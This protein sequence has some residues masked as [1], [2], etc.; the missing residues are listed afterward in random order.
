MSFK[1]SQ[2]D[3]FVDDSERSLIEKCFRDRWLTEGPFARAFQEALKSQTGANHVFFAPNGTLG[4]YLALLALDL[5]PG[6]EIVMPTFTFYASAT[7][8]VFA[9]LKPVFVDVD[10]NTFNATPHAFESAIGP[11]T[12]AF[13]P[14][15]IYG[16]ACDVE[17]IV[18][19]A[20]RHELKV[21][22]DAAQAL[23]VTLNGKAAGTFG[24][25]G[26]YSLFADKV[27]TS[28]EGGV[29]VTNSD[30]LANKLSLL[31]NQGRPNSGTFI[32]PSLGMNFRITDLQ[33]AM[34]LAQLEKFPQIV[35]DRTRKWQL[36]CDGLK[37]VGDLRFMRVLPGSSLIMFRFP[38]LTAEREGL[39]K[40]LE[41]NGI[42]TRSFFYPLH[43]QPKLKDTSG[44][45]LP[46]A[47]NL[48]EQG[49]CLPVHYHLSEP[50]I[51]EILEAIRSYFG[52]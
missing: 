9:G 22:E 14:V 30:D 6:A 42:E 44:V 7:A 4:L 49:I 41:S 8:A 45:K 29:V 27:I 48:Y 36:Y 52:S 19:V 2:I 1:I 43:L 10:P 46:V 20:R 33:A 17:G 25:S 37:G 15:H 28:G 24:D 3:L 31:R 23:G 13:M 38:L 39:V 32:H 51:G 16:Q 47:E 5:E 50:Q 35:A 18:A 26:V 34:G 40:H 12:R 21:V 11:R